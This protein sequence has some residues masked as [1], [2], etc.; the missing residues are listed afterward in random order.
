MRD[1][2]TRL[3]RLEVQAREQGLDADDD[4]SLS[5]LP[6]HLRRLL[7][8]M[9]PSERTLPPHLQRLLDQ[10]ESRQG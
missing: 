10:H 3:A 1:L 8:E 9:L 5:G 4:A 6:P 7:A 2:S